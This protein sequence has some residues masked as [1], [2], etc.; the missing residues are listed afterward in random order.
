MARQSHRQ[1]ALG[2]PMPVLVATID[3]TWLSTT[4]HEHCK[5]A[6]RAKGLQPRVGER[7]SR[8]RVE[9]QLCAD[10]RTVAITDANFDAGCSRNH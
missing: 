2:N 9:C 1:P 8:I 5:A 4:R 6:V 7:A 3:V 10:H